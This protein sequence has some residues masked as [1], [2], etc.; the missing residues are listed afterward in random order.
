MI[1]LIADAVVRRSGSRDR[2]NV[3]IFQPSSSSANSPRC[4][5]VY[6]D[7]EEGV[8]VRRS[9][10]RSTNRK[11]RSASGKTSESHCGNSDSGDSV[12]QR[13]KASAEA[14]VNP[15][16]EWV[17]QL[18]IYKGLVE[19]GEIVGDQFDSLQFVDETVL[20]AGSELPEKTAASKPATADSLHS[21]SNV[22]D[23]VCSVDRNISSAKDAAASSELADADTERVVIRGQFVTRD[24]IAR[25]P[26]K[27]QDL[28]R[29]KGSLGVVD[30]FRASVGIAELSDT[31][32]VDL[33]EPRTTRRLSKRDIATFLPIEN[34]PNL[35]SSPAGTKTVV[36]GKKPQAQIHYITLH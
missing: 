9:R 23:L 15:A 28:T 1:V 26:V 16:S 19:N 21:T 14:T 18:C 29:G 12:P 32:N 31:S 8:T 17:E 30:S 2:R 27:A 4:D 25:T 24:K 36:L 3:M 20:S 10:S 7:R 6:P 33:N 22:S 35:S 13:N 34:S 11:S 5:E